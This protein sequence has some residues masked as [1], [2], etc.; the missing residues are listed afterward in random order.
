MERI[1]VAFVTA[2]RHYGLDVPV[3]SALRYHEALGAVGVGQR[4]DVY[5]A[6]R[7]T[8]VHDQESV[9]IYDAVFAAFW[10]QTVV[11]GSQMVVVDEQ[12]MLL[13]IDT[14]DEDDVDGD[15]GA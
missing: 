4:D 12:E 5:W 7:A 14:G 1:A 15:E 11:V 9:P 3:G 8:L 2:L 6:G 13:A 10:E